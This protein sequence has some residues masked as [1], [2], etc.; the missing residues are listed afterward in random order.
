MPAAAPTGPAPDTIPKRTSCT[1]R[2]IKPAVS[3]ISLRKP[4]EGFSDIHYVLGRN[5]TEF[6]V[7]EGPGFGRA[8]DAASTNAAPQPARRPRARCAG[9]R[10]CGRR[11]TVQ[12]LSLVKPPYAVISAIN[13]DRGEIQWQ[14][15]YGETPDAV[16]NNPALKGMNIPNTGQPGSVGLVVTKTLVILGDS[17][18]TTRAASARRDAARL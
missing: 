15:P 9:S 14:V 6:R 5:D 13:L 12:G 3:P 1:H 2:R 16:R 10:A 17:Q 7:S 18:M 11:L 8:A 4:P